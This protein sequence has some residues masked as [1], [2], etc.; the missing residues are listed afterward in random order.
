M[1]NQ[2]MVIK[3]FTDPKLTRSAGS[4]AVRVN[5]EKYS[6]SFA[7]NYNDR[8]ALGSMNTAL[9]FAN[10]APSKLN[11]ELVFDAT[12]AIPGS[13]SDLAKEIA[14]FLKVVYNYDGSIHEPH[15][16]RLIWGKLNFSARLTSLDLQYTLFSPAGAPLR[17]RASVSFS[18]FVDPA[19]IA[20][21]EDRQSADLTRQYLVRKGD[22]LP[23]ISLTLYGAPGH[24]MK[25]ARA[26]GLT[27]TRELTEGTRLRCP[28]LR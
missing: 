15:Y 23:S 4:Y 19:T 10:M 16:L 9:R 18:N 13:A 8:P 11:F 14:A 25:L 5:P 7:V 22:T 21:L 1:S 20:K 24:Y 2:R 26:N 28:P 27:S 3:A 6:Q 12:G 17:A